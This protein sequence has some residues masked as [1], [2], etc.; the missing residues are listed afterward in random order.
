MEY[1]RYTE[2]V[3]AI[4]IDDYIKS[5]RPFI[6]SRGKLNIGISKDEFVYYNSSY[7]NNILSD[8]SNISFDHTLTDILV[9]SHTGIQLL[10]SSRDISG[11]ISSPM[12]I[13]ENSGDV[14][15]KVFEPSD[16]KLCIESIGLVIL[17]GK[18]V[19][20]DTVSGKSYSMG[21]N[22]DFYNETYAK[23]LA[24]GLNSPKIRENELGIEAEFSLKADYEPVDVCKEYK[25]IYIQKRTG[26]IN[27]FYSNLSEDKPADISELNMRILETKPLEE[28]ENEFKDALSTENYEKA[29]KIK[30]MIDERNG[31]KEKPSDNN[32]Q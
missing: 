13:L 10:N 22:L 28:L 15:L 11:L 3:N 17:N 4:I 32:M 2:P 27:M 12:L 29:K 9:P 8:K 23:W 24:R 7:T 16:L 19:N 31:V 5:Q 26:K 18:V 6:N 21:K 14:N 25:L 30:G 20:E 1:T